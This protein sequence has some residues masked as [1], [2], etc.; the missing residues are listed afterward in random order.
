[1]AGTIK[2]RDPR[3]SVWLGEGVWPGGPFDKVKIESWMETDVEK[4]KSKER[5][6]ML[7]AS[8]ELS[9][10]SVEPPAGLEVGTPSGN[11]DFHTDEGIL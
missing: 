2:V 11:T 3:E 7:E 10:S 6:M 8:N 9:G 4:L 5:E 1:L